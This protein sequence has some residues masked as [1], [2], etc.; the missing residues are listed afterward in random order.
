MR[1]DVR[2][3][4]APTEQQDA[5]RQQYQRGNC[6]SDGIPAALDGVGH[7]SL[8]SKKDNAPGERGRRL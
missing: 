3:D 8:N 6:E 2:I 1:P 4:I 5:Q 7:A